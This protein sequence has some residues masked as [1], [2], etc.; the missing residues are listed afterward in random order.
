MNLRVRL[1]YL[2]AIWLLIWITAAIV[3]TDLAFLEVE[4][5]DVVVTSLEMRTGNKG[6]KICELGLQIQGWHDQRSSDS[7]ICQLLSVG[8]SMK[9]K[10]TKLLGR[11]LA[12]YTKQNVKI[13]DDIL[14]NRVITDGIFVMLALIMPFLFMIDLPNRIKTTAAILFGFQVLGVLYFW[15]IFLK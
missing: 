11:W 1:N 14:E 8:D 12:L 9:L 3:F 10:E 6:G 13:T 4:R 15:A 7:K 5:N 2:L